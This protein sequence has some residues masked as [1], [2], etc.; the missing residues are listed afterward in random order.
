[1][2][3]GDESAF[4]QGTHRNGM[5]PIFTAPINVSSLLRE[6]FHGQHFL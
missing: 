3:T 2:T 4:M 1:M 5:M 6:K